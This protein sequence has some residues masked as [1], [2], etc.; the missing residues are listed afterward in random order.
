MAP[1]GAL[2]RLRAW[3]AGVDAEDIVLVREGFAWAAALLGPLWAL[4]HRLWGFALLIV[5]AEF[6]VAMVLELARDPALEGASALALAAL[7]GFAAHDA[8]RATLARRGMPATAIVAAPDSDAAL[9]RYLDRA[10]EPRAP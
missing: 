5:A 1:V 9:L 10:A 2:A 3:L 7:I 4:W 8:R 6:A